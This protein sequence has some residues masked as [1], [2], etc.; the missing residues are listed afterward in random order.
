MYEILGWYT[1]GIEATELD[2]R[3]QRQVTV[4]HTT[5]YIRFSVWL[6]ESVAKS[7]FPVSFL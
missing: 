2:L 4:A 1:V 5:V 3:I 7:R 6:L